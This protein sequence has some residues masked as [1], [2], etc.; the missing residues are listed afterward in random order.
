MKH[1]TEQELLEKENINIQNSII[2]KIDLNIVGHYGNTVSVEVQCKNCIAISGWNNTK[3]AG[4]VIKELIVLLGLDLENGRRLSSIQ[5]EPC[6]LVVEGGM[7]GKCVGI[8]HFMNDE[9]VLTEELMT[10]FQGG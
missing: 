2:K 3:S 6:R 7:L 5:N 8:G 4:L 10:T 9:F 1:Y